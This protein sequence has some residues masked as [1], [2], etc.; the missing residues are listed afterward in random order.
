[1]K[2]VVE[3]QCKSDQMFLEWE[4]QRM[5]FEAEQRKEEREF[6]LR[7][8]SVLLGSQRSQSF[9]PPNRPYNAYEQLD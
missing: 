7:M 2:D 4:E 8:L 3:A 6:Q 5:R 1:M 9:P